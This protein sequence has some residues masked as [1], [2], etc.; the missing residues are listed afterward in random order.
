M[1]KKEYLNILFVLLA[2]ALLFTGCGKKADENKPISEVEAE[3]EKLS[4]DKL[5]SMAVQYKDAIAAKKDEIEKVTARF[6]DI[7]IAEKLGSEA[8]ELQ[9]EIGNLNK[10]VSALNERF[11]IYYQKLKEKGGDLSGL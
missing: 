7:P 6:K 4:A 11:Q 8:K 10:S 5:R 2:V 9:A 3:A 1:G